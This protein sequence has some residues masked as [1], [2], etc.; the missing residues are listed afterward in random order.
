MADLPSN[1]NCPPA[2]DSPGG[3]P[4]RQ[5]RET[6]DTSTA[7]PHIPTY[8]SAA[9]QGGEG[10][11][12]AWPGR[13]LPAF[14]APGLAGP[15]DMLPGRPLS[16][17][18]PLADGSQS[19]AT[20][21]AAAAT[22][23]GAWALPPASVAA[24]YQTGQAR[25]VNRGLVVLIVAAAVLVAAV[26]FAI[27]IPTFLSTTR[28]ASGATWFNGGV[29]SDWV[30]A[31]VNGLASNEVL[32]A[33]WRTPGPTVDAFFPCVYV[34]RVD[35]TGS[36]NLSTGAWFGVLASEA[37]SR[38]WQSKQITLA[39]GAPALS[40][41]VAWGTGEDRSASNVPI[42]EYALYARQGTGFY[43]VTFMTSVQDYAWEEPAVTTV[44]DQ[45]KADDVGASSPG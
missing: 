6:S 4:R 28:V 34:V 9:S 44:V 14:P 45:F 11:E 25:P 40:I 22:P 30:P 20:V 32:E 21:P 43:R 33:A 15:D 24:Q 17:P 31:T 19:W 3:A 41:Y 8:Y 39:D 2:E 18:V 7:W 23:P 1:S 5:V 10:R 42:S 37:A 16:S 36:S 12:A 29:P 38:G 35:M 27:A 26:M 13:P